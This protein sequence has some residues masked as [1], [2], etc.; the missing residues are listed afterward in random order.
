MQQIDWNKPARLLLL[1]AEI[2]DNTS[3]DRGQITEAKDQS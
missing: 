3:S 1:L 2:H